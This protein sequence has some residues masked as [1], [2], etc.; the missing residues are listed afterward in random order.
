MEFNDF[1]LGFVTDIKHQA[2]VLD[3]KAH[4]KRTNRLRY[5][6]AWRDIKRVI[7]EKVKHRHFTLLL[8]LGRWRRQVAIMYFDVRDA[9]HL[10]FQF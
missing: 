6:V 4:M 9:R 1:G 2:F 5:S 8:N 3:R 7:F 10:R